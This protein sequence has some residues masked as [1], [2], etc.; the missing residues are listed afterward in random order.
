[1]SIEQI[2]ATQFFL[3]LVVVSL[4]S[5]WVVRPWLNGQ[6][7]QTAL[8]WLMVPHAFRHLGLVFVVPGVV[9]PS[10]PQ[11]FAGAAAYG[12]LAAGVLAIIAMIALKRNWL[13]MLP[14]A[15]LVNIVGI[16]D[17]ANALRQAEAIP[18][19]GAAWYIPTFVVPVLLVTHFTMV[20]LLIRRWRA[21]SQS[22]RAAISS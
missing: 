21:M 18:H 1:M 12:D 19:M 2:F 3:S 7:L 17:L 13:L 20:V 4:L 9:E 16:V 14:I 6:T 5:L 11:A 10:M 15:W 22:D 8:F